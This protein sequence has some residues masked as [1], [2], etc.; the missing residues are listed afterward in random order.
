MRH[1]Q[2]QKVRIAARL[3]TIDRTLAKIMELITNLDARVGQLERP[4]VKAKASAA[5]ASA[6][7]GGTNGSPSADSRGSGSQPVVS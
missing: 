7:H 1:P 6:V 5:A 3:A 4:K 2:T